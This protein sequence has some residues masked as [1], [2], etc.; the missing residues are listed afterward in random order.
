MVTIDLVLL[1]GLQSRLVLQTTLI[2][3]VLCGSGWLL[4]QQPGN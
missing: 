2:T 3:V 1:V 4:F